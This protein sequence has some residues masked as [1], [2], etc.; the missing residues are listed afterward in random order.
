M[1]RAKLCQYAENVHFGKP[2]GLMDQMACSVGGMCGIDFKTD[3]P[4]ITPLSYS[5][6]TPATRWWW[7]TAAAAMTT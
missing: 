4:Q 1:L 7:S 5:F 6:R 2:S 3:E